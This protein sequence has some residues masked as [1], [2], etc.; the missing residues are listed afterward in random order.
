MHLKTN[1]KLQGGQSPSIS[2][3]TT[4]PVR[5]WSQTAVKVC[6]PWSAPTVARSAAYGKTATEDGID[7]IEENVATNS[8]DKINTA[9]PELIRNLFMLTTDEML[10][11]QLNQEKFMVFRF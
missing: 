7:A 8:A 1:P 3:S 9:Q 5:W 4:T 11:A 2:C 6:W 10:E